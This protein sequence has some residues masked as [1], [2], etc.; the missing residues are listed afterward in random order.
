LQAEYDRHAKLPSLA[1]VYQF[2]L[3]A[4][5]SMLFDRIT[6]RLA[7]RS[8]ATITAGQQTAVN[9][10]PLSPRRPGGG[11]AKDA[12]SRDKAAPKHRLI[13]VYHWQFGFYAYDYQFPVCATY[14]KL[15]RNTTTLLNSFTIKC[16][17]V[18]IK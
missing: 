10:A 17:V 5:T 16:Y 2:P 13:V 1:A 9:V 4:P 3:Y 15:T 6:V 8:I 7:S 18:K 12:A 14:T 11:R